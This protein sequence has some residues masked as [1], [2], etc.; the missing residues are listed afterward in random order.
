VNADAVFAAP[1]AVALAMV[2]LATSRRGRRADLLA[3]GGGVV[4]GGALLLS[5]GVSALALP[6]IAVAVWRHRLR[7]L[8]WAALGSAVVVLAP[9]L[10]GFWW[11]DGLEKTRHQYAITI[12]SVRPYSYFVVA[13]LG[14][15]ALALGPATVAGLARMR[16]AGIWLVGGALAA[17]LAA[18]ISGLSKSEV[19]RIW[20]PFYPLLLLAG[21]F[22]ATNERS[23]RRWL[24]AQVAVA[25]VLQCT[26]RSPW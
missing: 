4:F 12:A 5:Y 13:N 3:V 19:E 21:A 18:D 22:V 8:A 10:F 2:V 20:Q 6:A 24:A 25:V 17:L 26:L 1:V 23:A 9:L 11:I 14:V 7:A 15:A 16:G